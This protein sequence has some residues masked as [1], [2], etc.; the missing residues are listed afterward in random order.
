MTETEQ[1]I[2]H[3]LRNI[4]AVPAAKIQP[5]T[6][7]NYDMGIDGADAHELILAIADEFQ[8]DFLDFP[9]DR[10]FGPEGIDLL[11]VIKDIFGGKS[12][13]LQPLSLQELAAYVDNKKS[14]CQ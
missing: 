3:I 4:C 2:A 7:I 10:Y 11:K 14:A 1:A 6:T 5:A 8:I 12:L 9:Y 13:R